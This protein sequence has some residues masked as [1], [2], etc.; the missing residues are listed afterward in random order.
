MKRKIL[1]ILV[2]ALLVGCYPVQWVDVSPDGKALLFS[3]PRKGVFW[4]TP[5]GKEV[6]RLAENGWCARFS[7]D[8]RYCVFMA[9]WNPASGQPPEQVDLVVYDLTAEERKVLRSWQ[10]PEDERVFILPS[11]RPDGKEIAYV[12]W[13]MK[14]QGEGQQT[15][16][17]II[18]L[19]TKSDRLIQKNVGIYCSWSQDGE[20]LAFYRSELEAPGLPKG[21]ALGSLSISEKDG[22]EAVAGL[23]LDSY[24]DVTWLSNDRILFVSPKISLPCSEREKNNMEEAVYVFDLAT[25]TA[26]P[27]YET[28]GVSWRALSSCLRLSPDRRRFLFGTHE[29]GS[30][31]GRGG[32]V[33]LWCYDLTSSTKTMIAEAEMD[34]YPFWLSNDKVG[35][36]ES[37]DKMV[38]AEITDK[39]QVVSKEPLELKELLAPFQPEKEPQPKPA[40]EPVEGE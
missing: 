4:L 29:P 35:Y 27:I 28:K 8:G 26:A 31:P 13:R 5:D 21:Y 25:K 20:R 39:S 15:E 17:H 1:A 40:P 2:V 7:P 9:G 22:A 24:A 19:E 23:L 33:R 38:I 10:T 6:K 30:E 12:L 32:K 16:L 36:F 37:E 18:N 14:K 3:D 34:A 11:W